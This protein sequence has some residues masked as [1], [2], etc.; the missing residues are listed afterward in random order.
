MLIKIKYFYKLLLK[1]VT[2]DVNI[3]L[4]FLGFFSENLK[5][6]VGAKNENGQK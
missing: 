4:V 3:F 6:K 2:K 5:K 1:M